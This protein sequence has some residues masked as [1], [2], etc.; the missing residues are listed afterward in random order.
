MV[1]TPTSPGF[2][3]VPPKA[4]VYKFRLYLTEKDV[5][6]DVGKAIKDEILNFSRNVIDPATGI[7]YVFSDELYAIADPS[8]D[9]DQ[10]DESPVFGELEELAE[11]LYRLGYRNAK[12]ISFPQYNNTD[13]DEHSATFY[14]GLPEDEQN[15]LNQK[16]IKMTTPKKPEPKLKLIWSQKEPGSKSV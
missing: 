11:A 9:H 2:S 10:F 16:I 8:P 12:E 15:T 1:R 6:E 4:E 13:Y 7:E 3:I 5:E 14:M